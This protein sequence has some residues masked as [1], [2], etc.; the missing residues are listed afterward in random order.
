ML[1][2][3]NLKVNASFVKQTQFRC[4]IQHKII[5]NHNLQLYGYT[6]DKQTAP[7][8]LPRTLI[9]ISVRP[10][11]GSLGHYRRMRHSNT[12]HLNLVILFHFIVIYIV[13]C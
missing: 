3:F 12:D 13:L 11:S 10:R 2:G 9:L 5:I 7:S 6:T 4:F 1:L 8:I